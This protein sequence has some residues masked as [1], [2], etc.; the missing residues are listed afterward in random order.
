MTLPREM[1]PGDHDLPVIATERPDPPQRPDW[2]SLFDDGVQPAMLL[3][4]ERRSQ[5][6]R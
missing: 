4:A 5:G 3:G 1:P 6:A 2:P